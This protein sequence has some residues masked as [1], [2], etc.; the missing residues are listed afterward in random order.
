MLLILP[1]TILRASGASQVS[2]SPTYP[3]R[4]R[5]THEQF[6]VR[7]QDPAPDP[8]D[9]PDDAPLALHALKATLGALTLVLGVPSVLVTAPALPVPRVLRRR[10]GQAASRLMY[11]VGALALAVL[12]TPICRVV[13]DVVMV[14]A[15]LST[16]AVPGAYIVFIHRNA[17]HADC[18]AIHAQP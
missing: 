16:Y 17:R 9:S 18:I 4:M 11:L 14:L 8:P 5:P 1:P 6:L 10:A 12:P 15:F 3:R 2:L 13:S 7:L